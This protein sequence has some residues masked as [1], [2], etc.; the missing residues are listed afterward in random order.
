MTMVLRSYVGKE[1][2]RLEALRVVRG[3]GRVG[4]QRR[5]Y[6]YDGLRF[7][8]PAPEGRPCLRKAKG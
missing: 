8:R 3:I 1:G 5:W 7:E 4:L 2:R 6:R